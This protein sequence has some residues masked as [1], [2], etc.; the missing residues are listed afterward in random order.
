MP[1]GLEQRLEALIDDLD[2]REGGKAKTQ[3]FWLRIGGIAAAVAL[4]LVV[5]GLYL[6][7]PEPTPELV[8]EQPTSTVEY[9][10]EAYLETVKALTL[11]SAN[12]NKGLDQ[13][14]MA[15][16]KIDRAN[17]IVNETLKNIRQ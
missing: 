4:V 11:V 6:S 15:E 5:G 9:P 12:L 2:R 3:A 17:T 1:E 10:E 7:W 16:T 14:A 13:L 8:A